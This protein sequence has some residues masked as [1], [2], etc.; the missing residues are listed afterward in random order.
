M[1][2]D[3]PKLPTFELDGKAIPFQP[4]QTILQAALAG[5]EFIPHLCFHPEVKPQG[6]CRLCTVKANGRETTACTT[7]VREG[8][9]VES[10]TPELNGDRRM[11]V[12]M[13]F[14]EGNHICPGCEKSGN[15][16]LQAAGYYLGMGGSTFP[17]FYPHRELDASHP[18][19]LLDRGRCIFCRLCMTA[20]RDLDGKNVFDLANRGVKT[21][22]VVNSP[23]GLLKDS[24]LEAGDKA[25]NI[26]PVGALLVKNKGFERPIGDRIFDHQDMAEFTVE[27]ARK[28][29]G[30]HDGQ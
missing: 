8:L 23:T 1:S 17:Y 30:D 6:S 3:T 24:G 11:L 19:V 22:L 18:D 10:N 29:L 20:S 16:L 12:E 15:C 9:K 5:G 25:A 27:R 4:G 28:V 14:I 26:C 7:P 13:L 2:D 21:H